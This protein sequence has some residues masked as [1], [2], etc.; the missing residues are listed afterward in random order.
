MGESNAE[1]AKQG[2][3]AR[4]EAGSELVVLLKQHQEEIATAWAE[5]VQAS[6][7]SSY[8]G[9][10][11][12]EVR[13]L[14]LRGLAAMAKS[15]ET[16]SCTVLDE[17]LVDVCPVN[18][19]AVPDV[20]AVTE[21]LLLCKDAALPIIRDACGPDSSATWALVSQL[22]ECLRWMVGRLTSLCTSEMS[23][24]L[25]EQRAQV[26]MLLDIAQTVSSTLELDEV[27]SR[28]AEEIVAALG[29]DA[30]TFNLVDEEQRSAVHLLQPSDWSSRVFRSFDSYTSYFHEVLTTREP[31]T[32]YDV[33]SDPRFPLDTA[34][35]IGAKS[36]VG[37][38]L[39][40]KGKVMAVAWAYTV[41]DYRHFTKE[42]I[43]LAQAI[44]NMLGLVIQNAQLYERSKLLAVMEERGRLSREIHDGIAQTLGALQLKASQIE[45]S[46]SSED[47][48]EPRRHLSELQDRISRAYRDLR[49]AM[50]G[51][52]AVVEPGTDLVTALREYL[53]HYQAQY[54]LDVRLE[55][56]EDEPVTLDGDTQAQLMRIVHE[57]LSNVRRHAGTDRATLRIERHGDAVRISM[58]DE[59][60]GFDA[61]LLEGRDDGRHLGLHSM[62]ERAASVGG[63]LAVESRPGQG[64]C[65]VLQL[66]LSWDGGPA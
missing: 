51:L 18:S 40:V 13:S 25:Q 4:D 56:N 39:M 20:A 23:R 65:V 24:K 42:E 43:A 6:P 8:R 19:E 36:T 3:G 66:P 57:A 7:G 9:L 2:R 15:L 62:R 28:V 64:A 54:G 58:V 47:V 31:V 11:R 32:S 49:E 60:R 55:A 12:E 35:E 22:D 48:D 46:L 30:C 26:A 45:D 63:T 29:V 44:G 1:Q 53:A 5:M 10:P 33:Q 59:G 61:S 41:D 50:L 17:Y 37:V 38:P 16:G 14:A 34:R 27:V 21:T 52:R